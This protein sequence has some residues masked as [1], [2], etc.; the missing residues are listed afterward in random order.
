[1]IAW[2]TA[3]WVALGGIAL[4]L[5][6]VVESIAVLLRANKVLSIISIIKEFF[7]IG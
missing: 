6:R 7:R 4:L 1:M 5:L 2:I 3:N